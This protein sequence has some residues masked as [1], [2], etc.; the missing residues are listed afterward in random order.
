MLTRKA[1][2]SPGGGAAASGLT[3]EAEEDEGRLQ[4][5]RARA[6]LSQRG[7]KAREPIAT[8]Y[9]GPVGEGFLPARTAGT[10][11]RGRLASR[12]SCAKIAAMDRRTFLSLIAVP[13]LALACARGSSE[14]KRLTVDEVEARIAAKDGKT[15]IYDNNP[16]DRFDKSH[17]PGARWVESGEVTAAVL[18]P[19]K[20]ATLIFYCANEW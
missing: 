18:P 9:H 15:F 12:T 3:A 14:L 2:R 6:R 8:L 20:G 5:E 4:A 10:D 16:K 13:A 17:L 11:F 7:K 1:E 19:D